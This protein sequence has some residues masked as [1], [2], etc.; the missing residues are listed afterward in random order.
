MHSS[1]RAQVR[2]AIVRS[3]V[4]SDRVS[5]E[6]RAPGQSTPTGIR[7]HNGAL[8]VRFNAEPTLHF[9]IL[10]SGNDWLCTFSNTDLVTQSRRRIFVAD[11]A[12]P[13]LLVLLQDWLRRAASG[14]HEPADELITA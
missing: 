10:R 1:Y 5:F 2:K 9:S 4:V 6:E 11:G 12:F 14:V 8:V 3:G 7:N 13:D